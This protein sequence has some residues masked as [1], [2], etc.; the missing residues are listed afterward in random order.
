MLVAWRS[1]IAGTVRIR[2]R[3]ADGDP[4]GGNGYGYSRS[5]DRRGHAIE[6][7]VAGVIG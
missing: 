6:S 3:V 5:P 4:N 7:L 1:P 2:G